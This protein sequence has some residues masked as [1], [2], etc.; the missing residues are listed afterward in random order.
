MK[1]K[2]DQFDRDIAAPD[3]QSSSHNIGDK[4]DVESHKS[5]RAD[6]SIATILEAKQNDDAK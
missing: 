5:G 6:K 3:N 4:S 1:E 2:L